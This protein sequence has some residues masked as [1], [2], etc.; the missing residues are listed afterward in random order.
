VTLAS[1]GASAAGALP[2]L[3]WKRLLDL[4][5]GVPLLVPCLPLIGLLALLVAIES[6]GPVL[7]GQERVGQDGTRFRMWKLRT[8]RN[9]SADGPHRVAAAAWLAGAGG[10]G[11]YK[12]LDDPRITR[13]GHWLRRFD[14]DE[15]PQL[16]NVL[17]GDMSLVGPRPAIPYELAMYRPEYLERLRV[18]PGMTGIWQLTRRDR[19]SGQEM[20]ELDLRYV[21]EVSPWL[22]LKLLALTGPVL[23]MAALRR[24]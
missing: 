22:D 7:F 10:G 8:M 20:M 9:G 15:L 16:L 1:H 5:I 18:P 3:W 6:R 4:L 17:K 13:A 12:T 14:L 2:N 11:P 21:S 19:L 24:G 23:L